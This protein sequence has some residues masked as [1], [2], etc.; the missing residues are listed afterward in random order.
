MLSA[1]EHKSLNFENFPSAEKHKGEFSRRQFW[2]RIIIFL[3][4]LM[5]SSIEHKRLNSG[6]DTLLKSKSVNS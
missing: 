3:F 2:K 5:L 4:E 6:I 1:I